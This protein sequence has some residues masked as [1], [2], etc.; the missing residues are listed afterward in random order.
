MSKS[1]Q[2][3]C[4]NSVLGKVA[5]LAFM[6][7]LPAMNFLQAGSL[8]AKPISGKVVSASDGEEL[9]GAYV[10]IQ[11]TSNGT[12]TDIN[13]NFTLDV[14]V[15]QTLVVSYIGFITQN[16]KVGAA[17][18]YTIRLVE[19]TNSLEDVV[20]VGY[21]T[22]KKKLVTGA[23]LQVKGE[24]VAKLNTTNPLQALQGQTP[25]M[26]II[27]ESGH[28]GE[29]LK[30]N[31]RGLGTTGSSGPLYIIDGVRGDIATVNPAD[32]ESI[33]VLKDAA[34]AAIYGN[35]SANGVVLVTTKKGKSGKAVV[36]FDGY[37]GWQ[38]VARKADM[39]NALIVDDSQDFLDFMSEVMSETYRVRVAH[40]GKEALQMIAQARPDI[41]LSD[42]MMPEMDGVELCR[43]IKQNFSTRSI[44]FV[45]LT[46]RI[47][48]EQKIEGME[49]GA[50]DYIT[51]PFNLDILAHRMSNLIG[52]SKGLPKPMIMPQVSEMEITS[53][54]EKLV[55]NATE[56]VEKNMENADF[57]VEML[58][59]ELGMSRVNLYKKL[60]SIT[61]KTPSE[62]IRMLRLQR[63]E[64]LLRQ[65]QMSVSEVAYKV[66]FN[67]PRYFSKYFKEEY[68]EMPSD[69]KEKHGK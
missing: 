57:S 61:G 6:L 54:D 9:I 23:T 15:G 31:I 28:P 42:V 7:L 60:L 64:Q 3:I 41:I 69:Y 56:Y 25:G 18:N 33:D 46:A 14:E 34:S 40:D 21:G 68:G 53:L 24:D 55:R 4:K 19:D 12:S 63:G 2:M 32:I 38:N 11:G 13:G 29:G 39:L 49:V 51:K 52:W 10:V 16:V 66:G 65:S 26:T 20:V 37:I 22:L 58:S 59:Q 17:N 36:S 50:D 44:P 35:Q 67:N 27:S 30:V 62:F 8:Q 5:A 43:R 1:L 47:A 45:M 48:T